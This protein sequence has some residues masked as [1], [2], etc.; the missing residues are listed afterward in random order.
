MADDQGHW[1]PG[2]VWIVGVLIGLVIIICL[3][4]VYTRIWI[5]RSFWWD[6]L[7]IILAVVR[8][9]LP[10]HYHLI[11]NMQSR[12]TSFIAGHNHWRRPLLRRSRLRLRQTLP[13]PVRSP[14]A[15]VSQ[16]HL[17][18]MDPNLRHPNVD[19]SVHLP[20][21]DAHPHLQALYAAAAGLGHIPNLL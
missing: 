12:L 19:Q 1:G 8:C 16:V 11:H 20:L 18:R 10:L 4:R 17:R 9:S 2:I 13:V 14:K 6:D 3:L 5:V 7:T 21:P 15:R